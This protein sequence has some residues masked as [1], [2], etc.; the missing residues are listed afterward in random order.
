MAN[1]KKA[2][3]LLSDVRAKLSDGLEYRTRTMKGVK[4]L[5]FSDLQTLELYAETIIKEGHY[6]GL[7]RK[8]LGGVGRCMAKYNL[9]EE[10]TF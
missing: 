7:L 3:T 10:N 9:I 2:Q 8:P 5:S 4:N 6:S 1:I